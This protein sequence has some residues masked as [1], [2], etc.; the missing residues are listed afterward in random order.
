MLGGRST[1]P[2]FALEDETRL[3][4]DTEQ[5]NGDSGTAITLSPCALMRVRMKSTS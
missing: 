5:Y 3:A 4:G 2:I 1:C